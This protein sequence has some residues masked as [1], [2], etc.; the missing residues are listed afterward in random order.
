MS[1]SFDPVS[2]TNEAAN[3]INSILTRKRNKRIAAAANI[4]Y[5]SGIIVIEMRNLR[6]RM[7]NLFG[8]L[9]GFNPT[10][11]PADRRATLIGK[12]REFADRLPT[13]GTMVER[14]FALEQLTVQPVQEVV[15]LRD[16]IIQNAFDISHVG[17]KESTDQVG[18]ATRAEA[19]HRIEARASE[20]GW[21][22]DVEE[23]QELGRNEEGALS[24]GEGPDLIIGYYLPA[25]LWLVRNA[26]AD[27]PEQVAALRV[28]A[29]GLLI[30][31]SNHGDQPLE[32]LVQETEVEFGRLTGLLM[33]NYPELPR[34]TWA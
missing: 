27:H 2:A 22:S 16:K 31:R 14:A 29:D 6:D 8:P 4:I 32:E 5:N 30:T 12:L 34:P 18:A 21:H 20:L 11:W 28:L 13:F 17:S 7:K 33:K 26:D 23:Y 19:Q 25:L 10:D 24:L 15:R 3:W 9:R 1:I